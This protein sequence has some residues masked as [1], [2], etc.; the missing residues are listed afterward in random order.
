MWIIIILSFITLHG[1]NSSEEG[2]RASS[3]MSRPTD[4]DSQSLIE[5]NPRPPSQRH[6]LFK[7]KAPTSA[8]STAS[9]SEISDS[10]EPEG[11]RSGSLPWLS[12]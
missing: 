4:S 12:H 5:F 2:S 11:Y 7:K 8:S 10:P 3:N 1:L 6:N 9:S